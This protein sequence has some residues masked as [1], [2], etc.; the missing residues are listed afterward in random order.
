MSTERVDESLHGLRG[1][2][3]NSSKNRVFLRTQKLQFE[4]ARESEGFSTSLDGLGTP[5]GATKSSRTNSSTRTQESTRENRIH[6][7]QNT[8]RTRLT[9]IQ[10]PREHKEDWVSFPT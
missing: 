8:R 7:K 4:G 2:E 5:Q 6:P 9:R 10:N 3:E 1:I